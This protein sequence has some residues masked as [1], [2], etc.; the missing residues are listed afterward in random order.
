MGDFNIN[1][2]CNIDKNTSNYVDIL[3]SHAF[4]PTINSPTRITA[5]SKILIDDNIFY[6]DV[7]TNIISGNITTSI[8]DHLTQFLLISNQNSSSENQMLNTDEKRS[9]RN[10]NSMAFE[11]DLKRINWNEAL[12]LSEENPN[13]PFKTFLDIV[14]R[15]TDK[16]CPNKLI[17]KTKRQTKSK[18]WITP[19]LS[20]STK[21]KMQQSLQTILQGK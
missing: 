10:I 14:G 7:A 20:N 16:H 9:F 4:F 13:L 1:L 19:A 18:P 21:I 3:Y 12:T 5:N 17:P 15:L 11:E 2:N 8:S 6:N